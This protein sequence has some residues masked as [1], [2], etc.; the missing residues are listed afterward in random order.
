MAVGSPFSPVP[1][2]STGRPTTPAGPSRSSWLAAQG[3]LPL[4]FMG[5]ALGWI[6]AAC[7]LALCQPEIFELPHQNPL[8]V[9]L[10]HAWVLGFLVTVACGAIY[11][12]VPVALGTT[13]W[14]ERLGWLHL[15]LHGVGVPIMVIAFRR[16]NLVLLGVGGSAVALGIT[17]FAFN[18][19]ATVKSSTRRDATAWSIV[20]ATAWLLSTVLAGLLLVA[21]RKWAFIPLDPIALLRAHAHLGLVGFFVTLLQGVGIQL[22]PMFTLG[23][24]KDWRLAKTGIWLSQLGLCAL[25]PALVWQVGPLETVGAAAIAAGLIFSGIGLIRALATRKKRR[26]DP[27]VVA[28]LRGGVGL[29]VVAGVGIVMSLIHPAHSTSSAGL[30][31]TIYGL[32][33]ILGAL[34]P[35][36]A[37]MM[38]KVVPFLTWM[39][40]YG[41]R[42]G[43]GP[44]PPAHSLTHPRIEH[45][46]LAL[47]QIAVIPLIVGV[48]RSDERWLQIGTWVLAAGVALFVVDMLG[49]M[50]HL[51]IQPALAP[52]PTLKPKSIS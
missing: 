37:G 27:G 50:K 42:V 46:A 17:C 3:R 48:W 1:E 41:P 24:V 45:W 43:R 33:A 39:R 11:Q 40:A 51:W 29:I 26:L 44:T 13:L 6:V 15:T 21:N 52:A 25:A 30:N 23:V 7:L 16:W 22:V 49:V 35:C 47:Q 38:C 12:L 5:L 19:W 14:S 9:A 8:V 2:P 28:F 32:L 34:V 36:V 31:P 18:T 20:L 10:T 4:A